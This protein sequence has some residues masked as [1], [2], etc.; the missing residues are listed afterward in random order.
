MEGMG[1]TVK[2]W[3]ELNPVLYQQI[4]GDSQSGMV[5]LGVLYFIIF[6]GIFGTVIMMVAER[7]KNLAFSSQ[8]ACRNPGSKE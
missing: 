7:K 3:Y 5:M 2:T 4:Q 1:T 6:F 8:L